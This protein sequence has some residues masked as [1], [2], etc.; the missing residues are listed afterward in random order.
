MS[1]TDNAA[2]RAAVRCIARFNLGINPPKQDILA[3]L[4][5][6]ERL[7]ASLDSMG[8][9]LRDEVTARLD[10]ETERDRLQKQYDR[11][12]CRSGFCEPRA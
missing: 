3:V 8:T 12:I 1:K 2:D 10:A 7:K 5:D 9:S 11:D 4:A 6:R